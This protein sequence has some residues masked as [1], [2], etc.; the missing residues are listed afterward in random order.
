MT[1]DRVL[2]C[3]CCSSAA[4]PIADKVGWMILSVDDGE[5][6]DYT[7][8]LCPECSIDF[9][10]FLSDAPRHYREARP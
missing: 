1:R 4:A 8:E 3:A 7:V 10:E 9:L 6:A 2:L 5:Q